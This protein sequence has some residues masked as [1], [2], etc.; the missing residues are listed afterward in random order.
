M[1]NKNA[2]IRFVHPF[3]KGPMWIFCPLSIWLSLIQPPDYI[4]GLFGFT[5]FGFG[6]DIMWGK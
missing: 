1:Y 3:C 4:Y 2:R 6:I 5:V